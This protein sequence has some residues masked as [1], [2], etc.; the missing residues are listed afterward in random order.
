[1]F[2]MNNGLK[3]K[4]LNAEW[5]EFRLSRELWP[6]TAGINWK[7]IKSP[8]LSRVCVINVKRIHNPELYKHKIPQK[9]SLLRSMVTNFAKM[10]WNYISLHFQ[11]VQSII[12]NRLIKCVLIRFSVFL[13]SNFLMHLA[14]IFH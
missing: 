5:D 7:Q 1:M 11:P 8:G 6:P 13:L 4:S 12:I 3:Q 14:L 10:H 2:K 9:Q